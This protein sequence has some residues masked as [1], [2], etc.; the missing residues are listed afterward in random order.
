[1]CRVCVFRVL[2]FRVFGGVGVLPPPP[3]LKTFVRKKAQKKE[4]L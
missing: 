1:M 2:Q 4:R 3:S